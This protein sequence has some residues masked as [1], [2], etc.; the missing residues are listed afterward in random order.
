MAVALGLSAQLLQSL[1]FDMGSDLNE[2]LDDLGFTAL[3]K[4]PSLWPLEDHVLQLN[5]ALRRL[6]RLERP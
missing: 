3:F 1:D 6:P 4:R 2:S 5:E